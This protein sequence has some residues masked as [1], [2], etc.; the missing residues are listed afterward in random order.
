[1]AGGYVIAWD[2]PSVGTPTFSRSKV[3]AK[4]RKIHNINKILITRAIKYVWFLLNISGFHSKKKKELKKILICVF[5]CFICVIFMP[6]TE[7]QNEKKKVLRDVLKY[8]FQGLKKVNSKR[9]ILPSTA[10]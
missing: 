8:S 5:S 2:S 4:D 3:L 7:C 9:E 6:N 10:S 1:M